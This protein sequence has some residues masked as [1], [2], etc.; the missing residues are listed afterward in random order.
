MKSIFPFLF[1][2]LTVSVSSAGVF[3]GVAVVEKGLVVLQPAESGVGSGRIVSQVRLELGDIVKVGEDGVC[4]VFFTEGTIVRLDKNSD[5]RVRRNGLWKILDGGEMVVADFATRMGSSTQRVPVSSKRNPLGEMTVDGECFYKFS[6]DEQWKS[7]G[8]LTMLYPGTMVKTT[9]NGWAFIVSSE[10]NLK[11]AIEPDSLV[12]F[13]HG[14][15]NF[16]RGGGLVF[17]P[18][19][20]DTLRFDASM[21]RIRPRSN[22]LLFRFRELDDGAW[23]HVYSGRLQFSLKAQGLPMSRMLA[24][25]TTTVLRRS[26]AIDRPQ[27][28]LDRSRAKDESSKVMKLFSDKSLAGLRSFLGDS[29]VE[30]AALN[31]ETEA[32]IADLRTK[33]P[34]QAPEEVSPIVSG[35]KQVPGEA[36]DLEALFQLPRM[37]RSESKKARP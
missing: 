28:F 30:A 22:S 1:L 9:T 21:S 15:I 7:A 26:G 6:K 2:F 4:S 17:A 29:T 19:K 12:Y 37:G 10:G 34:E 16:E 32:S 14:G 35:N 31:D 27:V 24:A 25:G 5:Y 11:A 23:I 13:L 18:E 8:D 36:G 20:G 3:V 33:K